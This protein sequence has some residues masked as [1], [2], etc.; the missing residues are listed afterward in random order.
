MA[1]DLGVEISGPRRH[2]GLQPRPINA[3]GDRDPADL[4]IVELAARLHQSGVEGEV[5]AL[6]V[7]RDGGP[8]GG[9]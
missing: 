1:G 4:V 5:A 8:R 2:V 6:T 7:R 3:G 9:M